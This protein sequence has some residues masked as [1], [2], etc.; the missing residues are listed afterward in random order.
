MAAPAE[1]LGEMN[2]D[3]QILRTA[4]KGGSLLMLMLLLLLRL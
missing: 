2:S 1:A 3:S 4:L